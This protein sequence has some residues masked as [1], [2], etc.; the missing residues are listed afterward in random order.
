[1]LQRLRSP[2]LQVILFSGKRDQARVSKVGQ[3]TRFWPLVICSFLNHWDLRQ[4]PKA[5]EQRS[6]QLKWEKEKEKEGEKFFFSFLNSFGNCDNIQAH[7]PLPP[8]LSLI[9]LKLFYRG[10]LLQKLCHATIFGC[11]TCGHS[12]AIVLSLSHFALISEPR[13]R[14]MEQKLVKREQKKK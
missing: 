6:K 10:T 12:L 1:M 9:E 4:F 11:W 14:N 5:S 2:P 7:I 8:T 3:N 13:P